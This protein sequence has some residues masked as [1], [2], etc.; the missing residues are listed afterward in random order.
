MKISKIIKTL[1]ESLEPVKKNLVN[2]TF[3]SELRPFENMY[4]NGNF[5]FRLS[6]WLNIDSRITK[7]GIMNRIQV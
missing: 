1:L 3:L 5:N 7:L 2:R 6:P 4:I